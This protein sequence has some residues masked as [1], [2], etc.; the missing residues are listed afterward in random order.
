M[1]AV[2]RPMNVRRKTARLNS[3]ETATCKQTHKVTRKDEKTAAKSRYDMALSNFS[4]WLS[5]KQLAEVSSIFPRTGMNT[6]FYKEL[7]QL[8]QRQPMNNNEFQ[9]LIK[10]DYVGYIDRSLR[11]AGFREPDLDPLVH[12]IVVKLIT[13][14][15]FKKVEGPFVARFAISVKNAIA[16]LVV[17]RK[18]NQDRYSDLELDT[19]P[20]RF[21]AAQSENDVVEQFRLFVEKALGKLALKVLDHRISGGDIIDLRGQAGLESHYSLKEIVKKIKLAARSFA[22][23]DP[24]FRDQIEQAFA[25][26][27]KTLARR[28]AV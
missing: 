16:T 12:D 7:E 25:A 11:N 18:R 14:S 3:H 6:L 8:H 21:A 5:Q 28:F 2:H 1:A 23:N 9:R 26:Q 10:I 17:K 27:K 24:E 15:L 13:G 22:E 4:K 19:V 20:Q